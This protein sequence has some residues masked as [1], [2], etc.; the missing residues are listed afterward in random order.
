MNGGLEVEDAGSQG[1]QSSEEPR[2]TLWQRL[3]RAAAAAGPACAA[4]AVATVAATRDGAEATREG[5]SRGAAKLD[6]WADRGVVSPGAGPSCRA[7]RPA[8]LT[9]VGPQVPLPCLCCAGGPHLP[10]QAARSQVHH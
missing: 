2:P 3:R 10:V 5:L 6:K 9:V 8:N 1:S 4:G 7:P